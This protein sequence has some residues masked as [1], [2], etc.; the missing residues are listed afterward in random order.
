L[1]S[2]D[3]IF[4]TKIRAT[5]AEL[6]YQIQVAS[7]ATQAESLIAEQRPRVVL[8]DLSA[9]DLCTPP[10]LCT[11]RK[12]AGPDAWFVAFGSHVDA[13]ALAAAKTAGCHAAIP[14]SRFASGLP[15]LIR[16][17]FSQFPPSDQETP[18]DAP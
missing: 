4:T 7:N 1:L 3:L 8:F 9:D 15:E 16:Q 12:L 17:Y 10:A 2:R 13:N 11:Y 6:G 14:R 18:I 5:A